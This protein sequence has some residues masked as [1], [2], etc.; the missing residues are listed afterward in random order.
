MNA[1][2]QTK[3]QE[4]QEKLSKVDWISG[5]DERRSADFTDQNDSLIMASLGSLGKIVSYRLSDIDL[6]NLAHTHEAPT[7][8]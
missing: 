8:R 4:L 1:D 6:H 7:R 2:Q 3:I 5:L